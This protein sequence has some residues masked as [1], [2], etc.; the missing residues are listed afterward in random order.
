[1]SRRTRSSALSW[2][3]NP[4]AM[5]TTLA[6]KSAEMLLASGEVVAHRSQRMASMGANPDAADRREMGRMV[7]EKVDA[8]AESAQ[9]MSMK[10]ASL[11]QASMMQWLNL[12]N[13][14]AAA[15]CGIGTSPRI[16][17]DVAAKKTM[18]AAAEIATAGMAPFHRRATGNAKRLRKPRS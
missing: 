6:T 11:Y 4:F 17:A 12:A 18:R 8:S 2:P 14:Q 13:R 16:S 7:Q 15:L 9:A 10:A 3:I 1:M 5:W